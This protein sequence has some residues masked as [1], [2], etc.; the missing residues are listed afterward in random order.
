MV[1]EEF[2]E[3]V[4][5]LVREKMGEDVIV[6]N[7][8]VQKNNGVLLTGLCIRKEGVNIA[9][10]IYLN[11]LY[12]Q[13]ERRNIGVNYEE[14][15]LI[16]DEIIS[17]YHNF[18]VDQ[19]I[20]LEMTL[21][22]DVMKEHIVYK[23]INYEQNRALLEEV[24]HDRY[25]DLAIVYYCSVY[26]DGYGYAAM[27]I[28][29]SVMKMWDVTIDE[30]R[31]YAN[32]NTPKLFPYRIK[33]LSQIAQDLAELKEL[34]LE[35]AEDMPR[36]YVLYTEGYGAGVILYDRILQD[37]ATAMDS[38]LLVIP[39]S[40]REVLVMAYECDAQIAHFN[41]LVK[42]VNREAVDEEERLSDHVYLYRRD[43]QELT[44]A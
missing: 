28:R 43:L 40:I 8:T 30:V 24:P 14:L 9:P 2:T 41:E 27:L 35:C 37:L 31:Q 13:Y 20:D 22:F 32:R 11:S 33:S 6:C 26:R 17:Q 7:Q 10:T 23:L 16:V 42:C 3:T 39:S 19:D 36:I 18:K 38:D 15:D 4:T 1:F 5:E 34:D 44:I 21:C 12:E 25:L 29:D